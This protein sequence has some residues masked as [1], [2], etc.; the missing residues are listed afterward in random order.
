LRNFLV[1]SSIGI[2]MSIAVAP[3]IADD[4][5]AIRVGI[6]GLDTSHAP[7]FTK[8]LNGDNPPPEVANCRVVA[9]FPKG[10]PDIES[11][12]S[13][14][15]EYTKEMEKMGVKIV[16]SIDELLTQVDAV[17]LESND[18]RPHLEQALPVLRAKKR[19]FVDKPM[20]GSLA[21]VVAIFQA[22]EELE[23][24]VFSSSALRFGKGTQAVRGGS[25][26]KVLGCD[27]YSPCS[28]EATHPDFYWYGIHGVEPLFAVMGTGC[29]AVSR[30][31]TEDSDVAVGRWSDGRIGSYRGMRVGK[32]PYGG[33]AFGTKEDATVGDY[34][35]YEPLVVE[36]VKFF[37]TGEVPVSSYET[38]ELFAFMT[39]ADESK[40]LDGKPVLVKPL[41]E[42][43]IV[44]A[45]G[46]L[47]KLESN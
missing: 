19:L 31:S 46:R 24:P 20:A 45:R 21:D 22:A 40:R 3:T 35:G 8:L 42:Q 1:R 6:I 36:I 4:P 34:D 12:V 13:R 14:V 39:A 10:S 33:T 47:T 15:P 11:S 38:I 30:I 29:E 16:G 9:A 23:T 18:G 7:A 37:R 41:I 5:P 25:I 26:G 43:A 44:E 28:L 32:K 17:M 2:L 27:T